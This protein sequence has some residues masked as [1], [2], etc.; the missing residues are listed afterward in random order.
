MA[1]EPQYLYRIL[2]RLAR[3]GKIVKR[4]HRYTVA[5]DAPE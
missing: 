4:G 1:I 3:A 5:Q 2:P